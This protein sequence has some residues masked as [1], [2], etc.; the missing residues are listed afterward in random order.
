MFKKILPA[1]LLSALP[2]LSAVYAATAIDAPIAARDTAEAIREEAKSLLAT[3]KYDHELRN[4]I[5]EMDRQ[6]RD[7]KG[8]LPAAR[9][10]LDA[11]SGTMSSVSLG[12]EEIERELADAQRRF[13]E[14]RAETDA[15]QASLVEAEERV[16]DARSH[17]ESM[18][19]FGRRSRRP[20][21]DYKVSKAEERMQAAEENRDAIAMEH[22]HA[23]IRMAEAQADLEKYAD[24][25]DKLNDAGPLY[26]DARIVLADLERDIE[27]LENERAAAAA[28]LDEARR[29]AKI[30]DRRWQYAMADME[31]YSWKDSR[32]HKG[33]QL[34]LPV[35][36]GYV[37]G[38]LSYG[39]SGGYISSDSNLPNG[40]VST[41]DDVTLSFAYEKIYKNFEAVYTLAVNTPTGKRTLY[42]SNAVMPEDLVRKP[43]FGEGWNFTPGVLLSWRVKPEDTWSLGLNY[44]INGRYRYDSSIPGGYTHPANGLGVMG[45]YKHAGATD[46]FVGE[47]YFTGY[48][49]AKDNG[50]KYRSGSQIEPHLLYNRVLDGKNDLMFYYWF[51]RSGAPSSRDPGFVP[52]RASNAHFF[53]T[54]WSR[55]LNAKSTLHITADYMKRTGI[56]YD[57]LTNY[58]ALPD[59]N[60]FTYGVKYDY[61]L[62]SDSKISLHLQRF[63]LR[64]SGGN[65]YRGNNVYVFYSVYW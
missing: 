47:L 54:M 60:K 32:Q 64:D 61:R 6:I 10:N 5:K 53:G 44:S 37:D 48:T 26:E 24:M 14:A 17:L 49:H 21:D 20:E 40:K 18:R 31:Y 29:P 11:A 46:Q 23:E 52:G 7:L 62:N 3:E 63:N 19:D 41:L 65:K 55:K 15:W 8:R 1:A 35:Q 27:L 13:D 39:V 22:A 42:G 38:A 2:A 58:S 33:R 51:S 16:S 43:R 9:A 56:P 59:H 50:V 30:G 57:P 25:R 12:R 45:R 34:Y 4:S 28:R 36:Y